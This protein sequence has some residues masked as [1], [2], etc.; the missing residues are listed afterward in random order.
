VPPPIL[1]NLPK[2]SI[3]GQTT[4]YAIGPAGYTGSGGVLPA[5]VVGFD[6]GAEAMTANYSL[7]SGPATLTII[8]YPTPQM[9]A[10]QESKIRA[11][12]KVGS[13]ALPPWPKPL[14]DSDQASLDVRRSGPLVAIVSG[15]A[16]P[17]ESHK[18][19]AS[20]HYD[21]ELI[22][23]PQPGESEVAKTGKLLLGIAA[24]VIIG[25]SAALLLG[26]FLGGG[27]ALYRIARGKP[28]SSVYEAEFI[29]LDLREEWVDS[30]ASP[31]RPHPK[32]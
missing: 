12:L 24:L 11:Y 19:L 17:D 10:A 14:I 32:G 18:L 5:D 31:N 20:V 30:A 13:Q 4:H 6:R 29:R 25:C 7:R 1:G 3:D 16:I 26:F 15:D 2:D 21:A 27:R 8:D 23:I 22:T 9:A 28:A